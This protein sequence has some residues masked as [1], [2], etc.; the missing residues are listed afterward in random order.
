MIKPSHRNFHHYKWIYKYV[1]FQYFQASKQNQHNK[2]N[3]LLYHTRYTILYNFVSIYIVIS[4]GQMHLEQFFT[5]TD[6]KEEKIEV[7]GYCHKDRLS[8][9]KLAHHHLGV[10][11]TYL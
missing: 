10:M 6:D 1:S 11:V 3:L 5:S 4:H 2:T 7:V 8:L 9:L